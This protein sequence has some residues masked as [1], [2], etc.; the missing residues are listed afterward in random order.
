MRDWKS[1]VLCLKKKCMQF[2]SYVP[3]PRKALINYFLK[4]VAGGG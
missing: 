1:V 2:C 3:G 4:A